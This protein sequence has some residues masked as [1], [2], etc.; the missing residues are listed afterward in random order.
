MGRAAPLIFVVY[1]VRHA[2]SRKAYVGKTSGR[3][4]PIYVA[5]RRFAA[6]IRDASSAS[7]LAFHRAIR[8]YGHNTFT[9]TLVGVYTT[10]I[11]AF[12]AE[13]RAIKKFR[14]FI[15]DP[16]SRGYNM[17][18]GGEGVSG[19]ILS[20]ES[21]A[22][23]AAKMR[24]RK[25]SPEQRKRMN[26]GRLGKP[27]S[28]ERKAKIGL[29]N[30]GRRHTAETR[31]K[32]SAAGKGRPMSEKTRDALLKAN[33]GRKHPEHV[34]IKMRGKRRP[35]SAEHRAKLSA[36]HKGKKQRPDWVAK[37]MASAAKTRRKL[38]EDC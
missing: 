15:N 11:E 14:T 5:S 24:G 31:E 38:R 37:R 8:K 9:L 20:P 29:A 33:I 27:L 35:L 3:G 16:N 23:I 1:H 2:P 19:K 6:H 13:I 17:T 30:K 22:K 26:A 10:E 25:L 7:E 36:A 28:E 34:K 18:R 21:R 12:A 4:S 32:I